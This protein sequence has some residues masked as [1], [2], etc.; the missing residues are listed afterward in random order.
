MNNTAILKEIAY[1]QWNSDTE[2]TYQNEQILDFVEVA[3]K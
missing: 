2:Q 1:L 3:M